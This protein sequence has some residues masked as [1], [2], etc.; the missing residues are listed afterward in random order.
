MDKQNNELPEALPSDAGQ[1][2]ETSLNLFT[3]SL[4]ANYKF[5]LIPLV[6]IGAYFAYK[7]YNK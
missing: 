4:K 1:T 7:K 6:L 2:K 3:S 5:I